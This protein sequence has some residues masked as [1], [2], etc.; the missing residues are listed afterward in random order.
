MWQTTHCCYW[1]MTQGGDRWR[2][3]RQLL[4]LKDSSL[5]NTLLSINLPSL[6][7]T[8]TSLSPTTN[9]LPLNS[10]TL[11]SGDFFCPSRLSQRFIA[12]RFHHRKP[13]GTKWAGTQTGQSA[14]SP[15]QFGSQASAVRYSSSSHLFP[16]SPH[17]LIQLPPTFLS[18]NFYFS[19]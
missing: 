3:W 1:A 11:P 13:W 16:P 18:F 5:R 15:G 14:S 6:V 7:R 8:P 9:G 19:L 2:R 12:T 10:Q 17:C 4:V